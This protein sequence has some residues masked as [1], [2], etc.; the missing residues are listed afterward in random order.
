MGAKNV[1]RLHTKNSTTND[2]KTVRKICTKKSTI[3]EAKN[4]TKYFSVKVLPNNCTNNWF[5]KIVS[6]MKQTF[7]KN[8][9]KIIVQITY[10][11]VRRFVQNHVD[12]FV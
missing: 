5:Q 3:N 1:R 8:C 2:I 11:C 12:K 10:N 9:V 6:K 7:Y 4:C